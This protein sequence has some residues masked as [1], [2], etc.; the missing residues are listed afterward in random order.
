VKLRAPHEPDTMQY[1]PPYDVLAHLRRLGRREDGVEDEEREALE[2]ELVRRFACSPEAGP[3]EGMGACRFV[4]QYAADHLGATIATLDPEGLR[5]IIFEIVPRKVSTDPSDAREIIEE[6]R[7]FY[8]FLERAHGL[9]QAKTCLRVLG[10]DAVNKLEAALSDPRN[11]GMAKSL[12]MA[13]H[14]AGYDVGT[15]EGLREWM[16]VVESGPLPDSIRLP[17]I[18]PP[19]S[20][21]PRAAARQKKNRRKASRKSRKKN[22]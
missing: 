11:F 9:K 12:V 14:D 16:R 20:P 21:P 5:E 7:A 2:D 8:T 1:R 18:D 15:E 22:R 19:F 13:G 3:L 10:G 4:M 6:M 17:S